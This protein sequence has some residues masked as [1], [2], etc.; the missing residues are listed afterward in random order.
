LQVLQLSQQLSQQSLRWHRPLNL[1]R[2]RSQ[3]DSLQQLSQQLLQESQQLL[4]PPPQP[5]EQLD[6]TGAAAGAAWTSPSAPVSHA[7]VNKRN[8]AFTRFPPTSRI[9]FGVEPSA[10]RTVT[11]WMIAVTACRWDSSDY[12]RILSSMLSAREEH[13]SLDSASLF[14]FP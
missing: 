7:G 6:V 12:F 2:M 5:P 8:A 14:R 10:L 3:H 4:Q 9:D 13:G 11:D 1:P